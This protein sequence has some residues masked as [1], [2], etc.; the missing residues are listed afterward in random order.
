MFNRRG[1]PGSETVVSF[2]HSKPYRVWKRR[3]AED[4]IYPAKHPF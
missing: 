1:A 2:L 4:I 3:N